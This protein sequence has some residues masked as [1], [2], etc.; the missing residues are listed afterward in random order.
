MGNA[1][2]QSHANGLEAGYRQGL[3]RLYWGNFESNVT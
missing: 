1:L 2:F 3:V